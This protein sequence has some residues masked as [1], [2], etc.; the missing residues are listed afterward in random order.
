MVRRGQPIQPKHLGQNLFEATGESVR[1]GVDQPN[2]SDIGCTAGSGSPVGRPSISD[3]GQLA[4]GGGTRA[5]LRLIHSWGWG[6]WVGVGW[7]SLITS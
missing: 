6:W 3:L 5:G 4:G 7:L 1:W 2:V